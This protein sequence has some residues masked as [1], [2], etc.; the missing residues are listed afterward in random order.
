ML[1][2]QAGIGV[3]VLL[4][5]LLGLLA[6]RT[7]V[8]GSVLLGEVMALTAV[9]D[10]V[11]AALGQAAGAGGELGRDGG[12]GAD[13]A[14]ESIL[15]VLDDGLAGLVA[16]IGG[17]GLTRGNRGVIDE[18]EEVLAVAS[19]DGDLLA[20]L[21]EGIEL[22]SVRSLDL[23]AGDVGELGLGNEGFGLGTDEL[24]LEDNN[25]GGVGLLVLELG[26]LVGDLL[27]AVT[28]GLHR[29]LDVADALHGD[30][31]LVIA[32]DVLVLEL[33]NFVQQDTK[34]VGDV[35]DV[36]VGTLA[37]DGELLLAVC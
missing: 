23:F 26:N 36:L 29:G 1:A 22:V 4:L 21:A 33:A 17:A 15:A 25:L 8:E 11:A 20:V 18:L 6:P 32:V 19:N 5:L 28:A 31:V 7:I 13:P 2:V 9:A 30:A 16:V 10:V 27:L 14:G 3:E 35:G 24:L 34:L 37:P 12:V